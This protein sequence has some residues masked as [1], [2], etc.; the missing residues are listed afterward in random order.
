MAAGFGPITSGSGGGGGTLEDDETA[1]ATAVGVAAERDDGVDAVAESLA[2]LEQ[3]PEPL[4][5]AAAAAVVDPEAAEAAA[6]IEAAAAMR[7]RLAAMIGD[8]EDS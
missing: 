4:C 6:A 7:A 8:I 3:S 5:R 2:E 1:A